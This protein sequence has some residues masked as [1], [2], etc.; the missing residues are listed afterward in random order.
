MS[1][2]GNENPRNDTPEYGQ[3]Q[4]PEYGQ[5]ASQYPGWDPYVYG[6]PEPVKPKDDDTKNQSAQ[7]AQ[8]ATNTNQNAPRNAQQYPGNNGQNGPHIE[9][10]QIDPNDPR[11]NPYYGHWDSL[12]IISF[13]VSFFV[14]ILSIPLAWVA[15]RRTK[16]LHTKGHGL[17]VAAMVISLIDIALNII[18]MMSGVNLLDVMMQYS[19]MGSYTGGGSSVSTSYVA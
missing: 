17:A 6:K 14:P 13:V 11:Q 1:D 8:A 7:N 19:G 18:L 3:Y 10:R 4:E 12:A 2:S 16:L 5:R 15:M 9:F